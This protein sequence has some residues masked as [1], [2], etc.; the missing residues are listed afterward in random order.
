MNT[1]FVKTKLLSAALAFLLLFVTACSSQGAQQPG[2]S[3]PE[4]EGSEAS[5]TGGEPIT[6][7]LAH[8]YPVNHV[9]HEKGYQVFKEL[10]EAKS[11][12][13]IKID[14]YPNSQLGA[15]YDMDKLV[16]DGVTDI[17]NITVAYFA[18]KMPVSQVFGLPGIYEDNWVGA[19][20]MWRSVHEG[21]IAEELTKSGFVPLM[22]ETAPLTEWFTTNKQIHNV[23]D[24]TGMKIRSTGGSMDQA[25]QLAGASPVKIQLAEV[26]TGLERNTLDGAT[27]NYSLATGY[28]IPEVTKYATEGGGLFPIGAIAA[29][30]SAEKFNELS[31]EQQQILY[32]A[33]KEASVTLADSF[34]NDSL[35]KKEKLADAGVTLVKVSDS[36]MSD[37]KVKMQPVYDKYVSVLN[38]RGLN[39]EEILQSVM[40]TIEEARQVSD[41]KVF[42][43]YDIITK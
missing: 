12:G 11:N 22:I 19:Q 16:T 20:A 29:S 33:G 21:P 14:I 31:K 2:A 43:D 26:Y 17:G 13:Q 38:E 3:N 37:A 18:D 1:T 6:L 39:G 8:F 34:I 42:P 23:D 9:L 40:A 7:R 28:S 35:A 24:I 25:L 41:K 4:S 5:S 27:M 36:F 10:V 30:M 15:A 32:E